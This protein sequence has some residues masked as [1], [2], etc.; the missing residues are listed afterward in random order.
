MLYIVCKFINYCKLNQIFIGPGRGSCVGSLLVYLIRITSVDPILHGLIFERFINL[1][2][3]STPDIDIDVSKDQRHLLLKAISEIFKDEFGNK[4]IVHIIAFS[5][6]I[7]KMMIKDLIRI[8]SNNIKFVELNNLLKVYDNY[9][10]LY[11]F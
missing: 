7:F 1:S 10:S 3:L 9:D 6:F 11:K 5:R 8:S 2:R 4:N